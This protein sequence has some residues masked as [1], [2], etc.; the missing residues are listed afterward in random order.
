MYFER[1]EKEAGA[2][3]DN[4]IIRKRKDETISRRG[5]QNLLSYCGISPSIWRIRGTHPGPRFPPTRKGLPIVNSQIFS[6]IK[7]SFW[8]S[9][10]KFSLYPFVLLSESYSFY[11]FRPGKSG[12]FTE[13]HRTIF[14]R[15]M[16]LS[17]KDVLR[18][19]KKAGSL[20]EVI[21]LLCASGFDAILTF[22]EIS[23]LIESDSPPTLAEL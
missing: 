21:Y 8:R 4:P 20:R 15:V 23:Q 17:V 16:P 13:F 14:L 1:L 11:S 2:V 3:R 12:S 18:E 19:P 10:S 7:I 5:L 6:I 9:K 22:A